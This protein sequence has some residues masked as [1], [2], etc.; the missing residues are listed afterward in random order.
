MKYISN[1]QQELLSEIRTSTEK[2]TSQKGI[3]SSFSRHYLSKC[4]KRSTVNFQKISF[5]DKNF[6]VKVAEISRETTYT[7]VVSHRSLFGQLSTC[8]LCNLILFC[9]KSNTIR[10]PLT[11]NDWSISD[12]QSI[13][14]R[15][16]GFRTV[17]L[18]QNNFSAG[19]NGS[20]LFFRINGRP[21]FVKGSNWIPSDSFRERV[22]N[23]KLRRLL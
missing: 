11:G 1:S 5:S 6:V 4:K 8:I 3:L 18:V 23:E 2:N 16:I 15:L 19:I 7:K 22:S 9:S 14:S 12:G 20:S 21:I 13:G 17:E 10:I